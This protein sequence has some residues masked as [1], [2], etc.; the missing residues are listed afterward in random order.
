VYN[1]ESVLIVQQNQRARAE[2]ILSPAWNSFFIVRDCRC[3]CRLL[4]YFWRLQ[5]DNYRYR[6]GLWQRP[7]PMKIPGAVVFKQPPRCDNLTANDQSLFVL[8]PLQRALSLSL[9]LSNCIVSSCLGATLVLTALSFRPSQRNQA[10][11][12]R[13]WGEEHVDQFEKSVKSSSQHPQ[14]RTQREKHTFHISHFT[15]TA[16]TIQKQNP[17]HALDEHNVI[18]HV[19]LIQFSSEK[20]S[21]S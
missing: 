17:T 5:F 12:N 20:Y 4:F 13:D 9:P 18:I 7:T 6:S 11:L 3:I 8:I 19:M 2:L 10:A 14:H 21:D 15:F 16:A 1:V